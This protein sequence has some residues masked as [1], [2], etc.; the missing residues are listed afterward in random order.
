MLSVAVG[1]GE[2]MA[3][4]KAA[5]AKAIQAARLF[6]LLAGAPY[7][8]DREGLRRWIKGEGRAIFGRIVDTDVVPVVKR[9]NLGTIVLA[10]CWLLWRGLVA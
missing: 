4:I 7:G 3:E 1:G 5:H 10:T 9:Q 2:R 8:D 6:Y